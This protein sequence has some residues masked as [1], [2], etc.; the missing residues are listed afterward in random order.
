MQYVVTLC[1]VK[2]DSCHVSA[3]RPQEHCS[4]EMDVLNFVEREIPSMTGVHQSGHLA[5]IHLGKEYMPI[6]CM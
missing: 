2:S 5:V 1:G 3:D 6:N 4:L